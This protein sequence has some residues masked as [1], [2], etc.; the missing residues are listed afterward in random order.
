MNAHPKPRKRQRALRRDA[1]T[2]RERILSVAAEL[3]SR[4]GTAVPL[5]TIAATAGVG[6]GTIYRG[7]PDRDAL[8]A[9]LQHRAFALLLTI[10]D[11]IQASGQTGAGAIETYLVEALA[12]ADHLI[13]PL[14]GATPVLDRETHDSRARIGTIL[15]QF[16][17][18]G[19]NDGTVRAD[20]TPLDV[21]VCGSMVTQ[22]LSP[23][24]DWSVAARR[25]IDT[26]IRGIRTTAG[27][28]VPAATTARPHGFENL[29]SEGQPDRATAA[30]EATEYGEPEVG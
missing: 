20:V 11:R 29:F 17:L 23:G 27:E 4:E 21:I 28:P 19:R 10:L 5:A 22:P 25:H 15:E 26:F 7:F 6:I 30:H 13:L 14:R 2:N 1:I 3:I 12:V 8:L 16:L 9:A 18:A 24:L